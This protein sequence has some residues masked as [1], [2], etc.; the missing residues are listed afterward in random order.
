[1]LKG[2]RNMPDTIWNSSLYDQ[3]H[4][5]VSEYGKSLLSLLD[6]QPGETILDLGCGTG[7]L[8]HEIAQSGA[9][10]IGID[11][12]ASMIEAAQAAYPDVTFHV[13]DA[14]DFSFPFSFDAI[15]SNAVLHWIPEAEHVVERIAVALRPGGRFVVELGGKDNVASITAAVEQALWQLTKVRATAGW[16]FPSIGEY[17]SL[18]EKHGLTV[19]S[20]V[21][22]ERPTPL[23]DGE[24]GLH[25][26]LE[27]FCE[28]LFRTVSTSVKQ[29]VIAMTED[30]LRERLFIDG[31]WVADYRRLRIV[32]YKD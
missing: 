30:A 7:H 32:A 17:A 26:W 3:K 9:R 21:L 10:V 13:M 31:H 1:M 15:F 24:Q 2:L 22:F 20:A 8:A 28:G 11:S 27:M 5:F 18:L 12:A 14:R 19:R 23:N 6:P 4:A 16:Y 25:N 29:Q